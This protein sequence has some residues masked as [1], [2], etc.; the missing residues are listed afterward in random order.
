MLSVA[1]FG[2]G[3]MGA[4]H[5]AAYAR[6][7]GVRVAAVVDPDYGRAQVL[8]GRF[9]ANAFADPGPVFADRGIQA[10][11]VCSPTPFHAEHVIAA[12]KAGK[13]VLCEKPLDITLAKMDEMIE[14][15]EENRIKLACV[16]QNRTLPNHH[17][18]REVLRSGK[19]GKLVLGDCY[20]KY[21]RSHAYYGSAGWRATWELD[22]GGCL[23][24]QGVHGVDLIQW[25]M[26]RVVRVN[27]HA[28]RLTRNI[29]VEDTVVALLEY[30]NGALGVLEGTTSI[31]PGEGM[32]VEIAGSKGSINLSN[33]KI[34]KW[35]VPG[36]ENPDVSE[37]SPG[38]PTTA[39]DP[40]A[41]AATGHQAH[42]EDLC[43][44]LRENR[45]PAIPGREGRH[46]VEIIKAIYL[47][48][49]EG[50]ATVELPLSCDDDG[51]GIYPSLAA[52][53]LQW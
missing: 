36:E 33:G 27:A 18:V 53:R 17:L 32:R 51:P 19:L 26:G 12:A 45:E 39:T 34:T 2:A 8:A 38:E 35:A 15:A 48:S 9:G 11:S 22:G 40:L 10:V 7:E 44:A 30:E 20:Q 16:F 6:R 14:A 42:V 46:A 13:H 1:I 47:S 3:F 52:P 50:G 41:L 4:T 23:M 25:L 28:R 24:N 21:T 5:A 37:A 49:R 29:A 31:L 43:A